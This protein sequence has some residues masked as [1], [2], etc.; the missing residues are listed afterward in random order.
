MGADIFNLLSSACLDSKNSSLTSKKH[1]YGLS[2]YDSP[3]TFRYVPGSEKTIAEEHSVYAPLSELVRYKSDFP[4]TYALDAELLVL[5]LPREYDNSHV[6]GPFTF[7]SSPSEDRIRLIRFAEIYKPGTWFDQFS[8]FNIQWNELELTGL[9]CYTR[10]IDFVPFFKDLLLRLVEKSNNGLTLREYLK[11]WNTSFKRWLPYWESLLNINMYPYIELASSLGYIVKNSYTE[12]LIADV[13]STLTPTPIRYPG[14]KRAF[15]QHLLN[16]MERLWKPKAQPKELTFDDY[17]NDWKLWTTSGAASEFRILNPSGKKYRFNKSSLP[18]AI[19]KQTL[20]ESR[21]Q[22]YKTILKME[23]GKVRIAYSAPSYFSLV[24]GYFCYKYSGI[25]EGVSHYDYIKLS[26]QEKLSTYCDM[27]DGF[28]EGSIGASSDIEKNDFIHDSYLDMFLT[29]AAL[30]NTDSQFKSHRSLSASDESLLLDLAKA[31]SINWVFIPVQVS[32]V[33]VKEHTNKGTHLVGR[34][35]ITSGRRFTSTINGTLNHVMSMMAA[36]LLPNQIVDDNP[37][38]FGGDDSYSEAKNYYSSWLRLLIQSNIL[39]TISP[40]KSYV[41]SSNGE[42]FRVAV[43]K[44]YRYGYLSRCIH[45]LISSN[46]VSKQEID[47]ISKIKS[48]KSGTEM[49]VRRG[50]SPDFMAELNDVYSLI[51]RV[52]S[53]M[54]Q[55][56]TTEGGIGSEPLQSV[57]Y[58]IK[59]GIPRFIQHTGEFLVNDDWFNQLQFP[60]P[61]QQVLDHYKTVMLQGVIDIETRQEDKIKYKSYLEKWR[62]M[63][64]KVKIYKNKIETYMLKL[65]NLGKVENTM[66]SLDYSLTDTGKSANKR[67]IVSQFQVFTKLLDT[68]NPFII[69]DFNKASDIIN[70]VRTD[71]KSVV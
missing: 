64:A 71:R 20:Y 27:S 28:S 67:V 15:T 16:I 13:I 50:A 14:S 58:S 49:A 55:S 43:N 12:N 33:M 26:N 61:D 35:G 63:K 45:S 37:N 41:S 30:R 65:K 6:V 22:P 66:S 10:S 70:L 47:L 38:L 39:L 42:F 34:G 25:I 17:L 18:I 21:Y 2:P 48:F 11:G 40:L 68:Y 53:E 19:D 4:Y 36:D 29:V 69:L 31:R 5:P 1:L 56:P 51:Q 54:R 3:L 23:T 57:I 46:P 52:T 7:Y 60:Y 8:K 9:Y 24:E 32:S 59:P 62:T 44:S